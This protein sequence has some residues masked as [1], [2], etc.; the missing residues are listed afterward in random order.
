MTLTL[1]QQLM[2][3]L[4]DVASDLDWPYEAPRV[5][6]NQQARLGRLRRTTVEGAITRNGAP[7]KV[8]AYA[9]VPRGEDPAGALALAEAHALQ[10]GWRVIGQLSDEYGRAHPWERAG[11]R[12]TLKTLRGGFGQGVVTVD[13]TA[14]SAAD[15][16]YE[17]TLHWLLD[18]FSF[19]EHVTPSTDRRAFA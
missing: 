14:V 7:Y 5:P 8:V 9:L 12:Q 11:W 1:A 15:D 10:R 13:R 2:N 16:Q 17:Q 18:H 6:V 3:L 4:D 19:V